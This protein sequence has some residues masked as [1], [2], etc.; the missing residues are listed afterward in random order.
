MGVTLHLAKLVFE[1]Y[2]KMISG[3]R[4]FFHLT[5]TSSSPPKNKKTVWNLFR[6]GS[7]NLYKPLYCG[8]NE[9]L[10][11]VIREILP[12]RRVPYHKSAIT[13]PSFNRGECI[14]VKRIFQTE[15]TAKRFQVL[16]WSIAII[17]RNI[18]ISF[19]CFICFGD[20]N[21][22]GTLSIF[23]KEI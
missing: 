3:Y 8:R 18:L 7:R 12:L 23:F 19:F 14:A 16:R 6:V 15:I 9:R 4:H 5:M 20:C 2:Q 22:A 17:S 1:N 11:V 10:V 13:R 21:P